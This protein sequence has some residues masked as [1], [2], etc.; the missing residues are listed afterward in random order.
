MV[1]LQELILMLFYG[2]FVSLWHNESLGDI[3]YWE[4]WKVVFEHMINKA[5]KS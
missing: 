2:T 5:S 3:G 1:V 4:G